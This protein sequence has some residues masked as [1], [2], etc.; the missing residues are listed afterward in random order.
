[1][2]DKYGFN[3]R[4]FNSTSTLSGRI[5]RDLSKVIIAL[6]TS[7]EVVEGFEK[8]TNWRF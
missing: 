3:P 8:N 2:Y 4:K 6:P 5:E 1:M 7:N